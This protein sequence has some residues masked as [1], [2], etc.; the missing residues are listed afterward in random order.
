MESIREKE[1]AVKRRTLKTGLA[2]LVFAE[3]CL[4][5]GW[6]W[7]CPPES[8]HVH[9]ATPPVSAGGYTVRVMSF[10]ILNGKSDFHVASW[11]KRRES[12]AKCIR[13]FGPDLLGTQ[14][15]LGFQA[16]YLQGQLPGYGFVGVGRDDGKQKGERAGIFFREDRFEKVQEGHFWLSETPDVAGSKS[17]LCL[18]P[19]MVSWVELQMR[20]DPGQRIFFFNTHFDALSIQARKKSAVLLRR[21]IENV[22]GSKPVIAVGDFNTYAGSATYRAVLNGAE[23]PGLKLIDSYRFAYPEPA[24]NEGSYHLPAGVRMN[25]RLDWILYTPQFRAQDAQIINSK[26]DGRY[27]SDHFPVTATLYLELEKGG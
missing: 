8:A 27:P 26:V 1:P 12:V 10:N 22:A 20:E 6:L 13:E 18:V 24:G 2:F 5:I 3:L 7:M 23:A 19:R 15:M 11:D 14:E 17:W 25:R 4:V 21:R 16:E 9:A